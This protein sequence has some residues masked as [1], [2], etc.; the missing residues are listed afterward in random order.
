[1][2]PKQAKQLIPIITA[3][4]EGKQIEM[5]T[6]SDLWKP[7]HENPSFNSSPNCYRIKKEPVLAKVWKTTDGLRL[8]AVQENWITIENKSTFDRWISDPFELKEE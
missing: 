5:K 4:A 1:M 3:F 2:T 7:I 6:S 8:V